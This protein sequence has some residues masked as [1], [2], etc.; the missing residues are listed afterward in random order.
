MHCIWV[1]YLNKQFHLCTVCDKF[2][3]TVYV[4]YRL[5]NMYKL[6]NKKQGLTKHKPM[7]IQ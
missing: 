4:Q 7:A 1:T 2:Q 5:R 3:V 6:V